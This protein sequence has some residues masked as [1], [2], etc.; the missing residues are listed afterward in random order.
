MM[1][2]LRVLN[3]STVEDYEDWCQVNGFSRNIKKT[4]PQ[5]AR[6]YNFYK[7]MTAESKLKQH[8]IEGN[9]RYK[10]KQIYEKQIKHNEFED[11]ILFEISRGFK[12]TAFPELLYQVLLHLGEITD[13]LESE[14]YV[15]GIIGLVN[16]RS[17]WIRPLEDWKPDTHNTGRQFSSLIR[18]L[19]AKYDVPIFMNIAWLSGKAK[20]QGWFIHMAEGKNIRKARGLPVELTKKMAHHFLKAPSGY[21]IEAALR[22][23]QVL[24]LGGHRDL[25]NAIN[26]TRLSSNFKENAFWLSV[27][28]FFIN[29]PMLDV[30]QVNPIIDYIWNQK[31][32]NRVEFIERGVAREIGPAQP[33]FC[34]AGRT[35][36]TLLRQV[37]RWH[38]QLGR[39]SRGGDL[40]WKKAEIRDFNFA[41]G[42]AK[43]SNMKVWTIR[44]LLSS[45]ELIAEGRAQNHCVASYAYSCYRGRTAI[46][47][48][49]MRDHDAITKMITIEIN[50]QTRQIC[51]VRGKRNRLPTN[52]EMDVLK[53]WTE[54]ESLQI[55]NYLM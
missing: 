12:N 20:H 48:M 47:T 39:E 30:A 4:A 14:C 53:R 19:L 31:Y 17:K 3:L 38:Q 46:F 55:S 54:K 24:A 45:K 1:H 2:F 44:E 34:M 49:N 50:L 18:H 51:Q 8:K 21:T 7:L 13:F 26:E 40:Q 9:K 33:N 27:I 11:S 41:E 10:I 28:Q 37:D 42:N 23:A 35:V 6:E 43:R 25:V 15:K 22:R 32:E 16:H 36:R 5:R 29:N 52:K